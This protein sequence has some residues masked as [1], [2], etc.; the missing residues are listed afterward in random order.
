MGGKTETGVVSGCSSLHYEHFLLMELGAMFLLGSILV[1]YVVDG[2]GGDD[3]SLCSTCG[4][5]TRD[6]D[7]GDL[8]TLCSVLRVF[9]LMDTEVLRCSAQHVENLLEVE[10]RAMLKR[11]AQRFCI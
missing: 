8:I 4:S 5:R 2:D 3:E 6:G 9:L 7:R 1:E 11:S 10:T